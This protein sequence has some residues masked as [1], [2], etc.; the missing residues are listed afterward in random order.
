VPLSTV[1]NKLKVF[2]RTPRRVLAF[3]K[4]K[5]LNQ[6]KFRKLTPGRLRKISIPTRIQEVII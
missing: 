4:A 2:E 3:K 1:R 6:I 5:T